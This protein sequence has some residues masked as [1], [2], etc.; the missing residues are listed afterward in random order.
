MAKLWKL[1]LVFVLVFASFCIQDVAWA[2]S[3][4]G[5]SGKLRVA[6]G[7]APGVAEELG[8][9]VW[10]GAETILYQFIAAEEG[11]C[12]AEIQLVPGLSQ[13][14][15]QLAQGKFDVVGGMITP[16]LERAE[17]YGAQ[18]LVYDMSGSAI[19]SKRGANGWRLFWNLLRF[20][21]WASFIA[22]NWI[23]ILVFG[24]ILLG[25]RFTEEDMLS[26]AQGELRK[27]QKCRSKYSLA[28]QLMIESATTK[29]YGWLA[30]RTLQ[31][32]LCCTGAF[33]FLVIVGVPNLAE[34][35][36]TPYV[37]VPDEL[38]SQDV[39]VIQG[40]VQEARAKEFGAIVHPTATLAELR[41][42]FNAPEI[43][44]ALV[45]SP[46]VKGLDFGAAPFVSSNFFGDSAGVGLA[47]SPNLPVPPS[48][49]WLK[50]LAAQGEGGKL[51][52]FFY[53]SLNGR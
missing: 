30:P 47:L 49:V 7:I 12:S 38:R 5:C 33:L 9:G 31:G 41:E 46:L 8:G 27:T 29:G 42:L 51:S 13:R 37:S 23:L 39:V 48:R 25:I 22:N 32:S 19:V 50:F 36:Q 10:Q 18:F 43:D 40:S 35:F 28:F 45:D 24:A 14:L 11:R 1:I 21:S 17:T 34:V 4:S 6:T 2:Q 15:A 44:A 20:N 52:Q 26:R 3:V 53:M 16:T